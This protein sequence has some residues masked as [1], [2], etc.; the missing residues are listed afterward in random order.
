MK[1]YPQSFMRFW[2]DKKSRTL[3]ATLLIVLI[4]CAFPAIAQAHTPH[5]CPDGIADTPML[6]GH[7]DQ[8][9]IADG[10]MTFDEIFAAGKLLFDGDFAL[11]E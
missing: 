2:H 9:K 10:T 4:I 6:S 11:I 1:P 3:F 7:L 8:S 5:T